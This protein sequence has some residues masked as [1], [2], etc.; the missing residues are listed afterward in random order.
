[1]G[2]KENTLKNGFEGKYIKKSLSDIMDRYLCKRAKFNCIILP[3]ADKRN[4]E[5]F[6]SLVHDQWKNLNEL[7]G[8]DLDIYYSETDIG[9]TGYD[10]AARL[11]SLPNELKK[12]TQFN[13][14]EGRHYKGKS[15]SNSRS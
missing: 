10:I 3:L 15:N 4:R 1:M 5:V 14:M 12:S 11:H 9:K 7:S 13:Y 8:D 2:L 6:R